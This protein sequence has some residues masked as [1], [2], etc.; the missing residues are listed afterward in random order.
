M[1]AR[2]INTL[3]LIKVFGAGLVITAHYS[4]VFYERAFYSF[5]TGCFFVVAGYYALTWERSRGIVYFAKRMIRL[6]PGYLA[7]VFAYLITTPSAWEEWPPLLLHHLALLL[8]ASRVETVYALNPAF[9]S[10][11]V[12]VTFFAIIA[13][14]P[15]FTPTFR[16]VAMLAVLPFVV[17]TL[18]GLE[19]RNG[20]LQ[21][22]AFPLYFYAFVLGGA[23]GHVMRHHAQKPSAGFTIAAVALAVAVVTA[24]AFYKPLGLDAPKLVTFLYEEIMTVLYGALLWCLLNSPLVD[25]KLP[26]I[27]FAG[28]ISF[29]IYLFHNLPPHVFKPLLPPIPAIALS[30]VATMLLAWLSLIAIERP[31]QRWL[32]P[33]LSNHSPARA[34]SG[35]QGQ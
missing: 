5:G 26:L 20:Y 2:T 34:Q 30:L 3:S 9:W 15:R 4:S 28:N 7:A 13:C 8:T 1:N 14:L 19:W 11:P 10:L 31:I 32:K 22:W 25:R 17:I 24:G 12:F 23:I 29:G 6:Y 33:K 18:G 16:S 35:T 27:S 21:L